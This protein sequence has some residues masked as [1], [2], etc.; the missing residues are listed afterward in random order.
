MIDSGRKARKCEVGFRE[1]VSAWCDDW[2]IEL[3]VAEVSGMR[4]RAKSLDVV[5]SSGC[6]GRA[7]AQT[8][9]GLGASA[10]KSEG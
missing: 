2:V 10:V 3:Q 4:C 5:G 7:S 8:D 1:N 6:S 9:T